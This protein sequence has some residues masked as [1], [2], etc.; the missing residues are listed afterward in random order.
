MNTSQRT[1]FMTPTQNAT[2]PGTV[3]W[4]TAS[5][6]LKAEW[7]KPVP[8]IPN[9]SNIEEAVL[10]PGESFTDPNSYRFFAE[11][12]SYYCA[13]FG[14]PDPNGNIGQLSHH[15]PQ[16][17]LTGYTTH[18]SI[19]NE[20]DAHWTWPNDFGY[21]T[22]EELAALAHAA[23]G[24]VVTTDIYDGSSNTNT[25]NV[26][27]TDTDSDMQIISPALHEMDMVYYLQFMNDLRILRA[28]NNFQF[29]INAFHHYSAYRA[30]D[31]QDL[32]GTAVDITAEDIVPLSVLEQNREIDYDLDPN[33]VL[34]TVTLESNTSQATSFW[35]CPELDGYKQRG[36]AVK[37]ALDNI[38]IT[39]P[40]WITEWG[41]ATYKGV[42]PNNIAKYPP[43]YDGEEF[44]NENNKVPGDEEAQ[45][46]WMMRGYL[47]YDASA[48]EASFWHW[49][50]DGSANTWAEK[51]GIIDDEGS[52]KPAWFYLHTM[53]S[54]IGERKLVDQYQL[55]ICDEGDNYA[56]P[57]QAINNEAVAFIDP[58]ITCPRIYK[59]TGDSECN[60]NCY[61]DYN[62]TVYAI[63][64]PYMSNSIIEDVPITMAELGVS[65]SD[66]PI[67]YYITTPGNGQ[68]DGENSVIKPVIIN[69]MD[70]SQNFIT[71]N[72]SEKPVFL[73]LRGERPCNNTNQD[74]GQNGCSYN[75]SISNVIEY[76]TSIE[77]RV[78]L[79]ANGTDCMT[80]SMT[81]SLNSVIASIGSNNNPD[82]GDPTF[83]IL[84]DVNLGT[85]NNEFLV[86][87]AGLT[88]GQEYNFS[89]GTEFQIGNDLGY[90]GGETENFTTLSNGCFS[91]VI[92]DACNLNLQWGNV[93]L[94]V[95]INASAYTDIELGG[96]QIQSQI[97]QTDAPNGSNSIPLPAIPFYDWEEAMTPYSHST[98]IPIDGLLSPFA[99]YEV[100]VSL[101]DS[102]GN[103]F[104]NPVTC[105]FTTIGNLPGGNDPNMMIDDFT[106][107]T[108]DSECLYNF[109]FN[110]IELFPD[111]YVTEY[112]L[113]V[114]D[115]GGNK[116]ESYMGFD[117]NDGI[118]FC[119]NSVDLG[120]LTAPPFVAQ[121]VAIYNG[122]TTYG[123]FI[124][125]PVCCSAL[126][127]PPEITVYE[128]RHCWKS[129]FAY[130]DFC[131]DDFC[132][133]CNLSISVTSDYTSE[134]VI[135]LGNNC[136]QVRLFKQPKWICDEMN[137]HITVYADGVEII[138][139]HDFIDYSD[140]CVE[141]QTCCEPIP[142]SCCAVS[143]GLV[144]IN[145]TTVGY[146]DNG[147]LQL[148][149]EV[150]ELKMKIQ[151]S[152]ADGI[153]VYYVV[154]DLQTGSILAFNKYYG[155]V[156]LDLPELFLGS[157]ALNSRYAI[158]F[159]MN[160]DVYSLI[161]SNMP[162]FNNSFRLENDSQAPDQVRVFPNPSSGEITVSLNQGSIKTLTL[163]SLL[164]K[165]ISSFSAKGK[166]VKW[167]APVSQTGIYIIEVLTEQGKRFKQKVIILK[168]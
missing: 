57:I 139:F 152:K 19:F 161:F 52:R 131:F 33:N 153:P 44:G 6:G 121:I 59:Y 30:F 68:V 18:I 141:V 145:P 116:F 79:S 147:R 105:N 88:P 137:Y 17:A 9:P 118:P 103:I 78:T 41:Y 157:T 167:Q 136:F 15:N 56:A 133:D 109:C 85:T 148:S 142:L 162:S 22:P 7:R 168:E 98:H 63:W 101:A 31:L 35:I 39:T 119:F 2:I 151:Q 32:F 149:L 113:E 37:Q 122:S 26:G 84:A 111:T 40:I 73:H 96:L 80:P 53:M 134:E 66:H 90:I 89:L 49:F 138:T 128:Y 129:E 82:E 13:I 86:T 71:M 158:D 69:I 43:E 92:L 91:D 112:R 132:G 1:I 38:G 51:T 72:L 93:G 125:V 70:Q 99:D 140:C 46:R 8:F 120:Q 77:F 102:E 108:T 106:D 50:E 123:S 76:C 100:I 104:G 11:L 126:S 45:A 65:D 166:E 58:G 97:L 165:K 143:Q 114:N 159:L 154:N 144:T 55:D 95:N 115:Q 61:E 124:D 81:N 163:F 107:I 3:E 27:I 54:E 156:N 62:E 42:S 146:P 117:P 24:G 64:L 83:T 16:E 164:G 155:S 160:D 110:P 21:T 28:D 12:M 60:S 4:F 34:N 130:L 127:D 74:N 23:I 36:E 47:E 5:N 10:A 94:D 20:P 48:F 25:V 150:T 29:D 87:M 135:D 75:M 67:Q 14:T